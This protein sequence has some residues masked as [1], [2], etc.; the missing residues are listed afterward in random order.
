MSPGLSPAWH[1]L[2][3]QQALNV[4][5]TTFGLD[6]VS[7]L[8]PHLC[9]NHRPVSPHSRASPSLRLRRTRGFPEPSHRIIASAMCVWG[10]LGGH[11]HPHCTDK[12]PEPHNGEKTR[13]KLAP[14]DMSRLLSPPQRDSRPP[15]LGAPEPAGSGE[16]DRRREPELGSSSAAQPT[17]GNQGPCLGLSLGLF[18]RGAQEAELRKPWKCAQAASAVL[19]PQL[20]LQ[21]RLR[22]PAAICSPLG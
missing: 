14:L 7:S 5:Q 16:G 3:A 11:D 17:G 6:L 10:G 15:S 1:A 12:E 22:Q 21:G 19:S 20:L 2:G 9:S 18:R 4:A 8:W 13:L